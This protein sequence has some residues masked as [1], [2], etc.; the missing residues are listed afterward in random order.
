LGIPCDAA[1]ELSKEL[2]SKSDERGTQP[3]PEAQKTGAN[4]LQ[5]IKK[6]A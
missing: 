4:G 2:L 6:T 5:K 3:F 1:E